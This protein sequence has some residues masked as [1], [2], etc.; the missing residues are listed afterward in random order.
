M[1]DDD[2]LV[3]AVNNYQMIPLHAYVVHIDMVS[4]Q[5]VSYKL[6]KE[7]I[8]ALITY[9]KDIYCEDIAAN[10]WSWS[11]KDAQL[12]KLQENFV[13]AANRYVFRSNVK[14]LE[15][16]EDDGAGEL[17]E[18][19]SEDVKNAILGLFLPL[20]P[21]PP[22]I[23]E[24]VEPIAAI[25]GPESMNQWWP[26]TQEGDC[27]PTIFLEPWQVLESMA[28]VTA[29]SPPEAAY[30]TTPTDWLSPHMLEETY[31]P[32]PTPSYDQSYLFPE[33]QYTAPKAV[34]PTPSLP[35]PSVIAQHY[36]IN[37]GGNG[38]SNMVWAPYNDFTPSFPIHT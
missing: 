36:G 4:E 34:P 22:R 19:R 15:G 38:L 3:E 18:G 11:E 20:L 23:P 33:M 37:V 8:Q 1:K 29:M 13:S 10:T 32:S 14:A 16:L 25:Y 7:T 12:K 26:V 28:P 5:E 31:F 27:Y 24:I 9:H 17:L 2:P 30:D 21:P 35:L 6:T